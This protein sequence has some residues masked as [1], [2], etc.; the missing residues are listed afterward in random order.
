MDPQMYVMYSTYNLAKK[1]ALF[2]LLSFPSFLSFWAFYVVNVRYAWERGGGG[3]NQ[4]ISKTQSHRP[5]V[6]F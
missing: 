5:F 6:L 4:A 3:G 2:F 1:F